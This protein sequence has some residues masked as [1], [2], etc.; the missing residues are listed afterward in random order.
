M[1]LPFCPLPR[2]AQEA[3]NAQRRAALLR[4][5]EDMQGELEGAIE[6][7]SGRAGYDE[8]RRQMQRSLLHTMLQRKRLAQVGGAAVCPLLGS[9]AGAR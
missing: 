2:V 4:E 8:L 9:G 5:L 3:Q 1:P 7:Y 6:M